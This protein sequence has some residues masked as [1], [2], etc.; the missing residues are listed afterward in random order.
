[1]TQKLFR[2][3]ASGETLSHSGKTSIFREFPRP[4]YGGFGLVLKSFF[5]FRMRPET[6]AYGPLRIGQVCGSV[7]APVG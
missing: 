2:S 3:R 6:R 5:K 4:Y 1:M 7:G